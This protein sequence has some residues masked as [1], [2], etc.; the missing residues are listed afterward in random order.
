[1]VARVGTRRAGGSCCSSYLPCVATWS[2]LPVWE[3]LCKMAALGHKTRLARSQVY[4]KKA[5]RL[6]FCREVVV[7]WVKGL[8]EAVPVQNGGPWVGTRLAGGSCCSSCLPCVATWSHLANVL[9]GGCSSPTPWAVAVDQRHSEARILTFVHKQQAHTSPIP[10][11]GM[12]E[13]TAS[14]PL[15]KHVFRPTPV[16]NEGLRPYTAL[17]ESFIKWGPMHLQ[18]KSKHPKP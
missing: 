15:W 5:S 14:G 11:N 6:S 4:W 9:L 2:H 7:L 8:P 18:E 1:M 3:S 17:Q 12:C 13:L 10:P 16:Q